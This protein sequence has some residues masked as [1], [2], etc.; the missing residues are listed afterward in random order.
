MGRAPSLADLDDGNLK[1]TTDFRKVY[2]TMLRGWMGLADTTG[3][4]EGDYPPL[5]VFT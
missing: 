2:A 1:M 5:D 3:V 4:L